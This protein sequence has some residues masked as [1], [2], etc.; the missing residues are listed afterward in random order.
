MSL[1]DHKKNVLDQLDAISKRPAMYFGSEENVASAESYL[2]GYNAA[3]SVTL[4][5]D[6]HG[7]SDLYGETMIQRGWK[8]SAAGV[9]HQMRE[10]GLS[11]KEIVAELIQIELQCFKQFFDR[12]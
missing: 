10:K 11:D 8:W 1:N 2:H 6:Y 5:G 3:L 12:N 9:T 7:I 4:T